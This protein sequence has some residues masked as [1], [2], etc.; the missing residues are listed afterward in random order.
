MAQV[1]IGIVSEIIKFVI[2]HASKLERNLQYNIPLGCFE[3][4]IL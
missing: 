3:V 1:K 4:Y 2:I